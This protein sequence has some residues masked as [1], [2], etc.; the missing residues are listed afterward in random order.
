VKCR[1]VSP[2]EPSYSRCRDLSPKRDLPASGFGFIFPRRDLPAPGIWRDT[3]SHHH[4]GRPLLPPLSGEWLHFLIAEI[5]VGPHAALFACRKLS[6]A[7]R[8]RGLCAAPAVSCPLPP[9]LH[10]VGSSERA[11]I[12]ISPIPPCQKFPLGAART[13]PEPESL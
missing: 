3:A 13:H 4:G 10:Q 1:T 5:S 2:R 8:K 9:S 6:P 11:R 7:A 12:R